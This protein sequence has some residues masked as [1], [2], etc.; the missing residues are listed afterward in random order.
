MTKA[1]QLAATA[2]LGVLLSSPRPALPSLATTPTAPSF[3]LAMLPPEAASGWGPC[4]PE[5]GPSARLAT[6]RLPPS[7]V[8]AAVGPCE[9]A[10]ASFPCTPA[11]AIVPPPTPPPVLAGCYWC[12]DARA[13]PLACGACRR[14]HSLSDT[15]LFRTSF[16]LPPCLYHLHSVP[17]FACMHVLCKAAKT[18][19]GCAGGQ[20][21][22]V[23]LGRSHKIGA[24]LPI[25][26]RPWQY[27]RDD[28]H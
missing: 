9:F 14:P 6:C 21:V 27:R 24:A 11:G 4:W 19:R 18:A 25:P 20:R 15:D 28:G 7:I 10:P 26:R 13:A 2:P 16:D 3:T 23:R 17:I 12:V 8:G 1:R 22:A 5:P